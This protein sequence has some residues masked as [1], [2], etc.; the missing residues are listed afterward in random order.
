MEDF[1]LNKYSMVIVAF[2]VVILLSVPLTF[3]EFQPPEELSIS[4][5]NKQGQWIDASQLGTQETQGKV[6]AKFDVD[7]QEFTQTRVSGK[8]S[9][10]SLM[11][12]DGLHSEIIDGDFSRTYY[13]VVTSIEIKEIPKPTLDVTTLPDPSLNL[14]AKGLKLGQCVVDNYLNE[15]GTKNFFL[16]GG[17]GF[18]AGLKS[19]YSCL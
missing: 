18:S 3:A 5:L 4:Y 9:E 7:Y 17:F 8:I 19:G 1:I 12:V 11:V 6:E 15:L 16:D 14:F 13:W 10:P 2:V